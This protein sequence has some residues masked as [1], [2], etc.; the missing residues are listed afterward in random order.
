[1][2]PHRA[3]GRVK[4]KKY[5]TI[6]FHAILGYNACSIAP[7]YCTLAY[8]PN[9]KDVN[10][11]MIKALMNWMGWRGCCHSLTKTG[12]KT[13]AVTAKVAMGGTWGK[14]PKAES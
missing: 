14:T 2:R 13:A 3:R 9:M 10:E 11:Q 5:Q 6:I 12:I 7:P 8:Q 1:M 4:S